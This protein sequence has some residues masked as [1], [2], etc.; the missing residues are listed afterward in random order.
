M[1]KLDERIKISKALFELLDQFKKEDDDEYQ[2]YAAYICFSTLGGVLLHIY[3]EKVFDDFVSNIKTKR[4]DSDF[5][6]VK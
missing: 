1:K 3:G 2:N 4:K 6:E 5:P